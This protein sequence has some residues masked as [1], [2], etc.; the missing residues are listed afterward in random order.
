MAP[1]AVSAKQSQ[2]GYKSFVIS[3]QVPNLAPHHQHHFPTLASHRTDNQTL[4]FQGSLGFR[5]HTLSRAGK[6]RARTPT[7]KQLRI[8]YQIRAHTNHALE[9][10]H[11]TAQTQARSASTTR[12]DRGPQQGSGKV[13]GSLVVQAELVIHSIIIVVKQISKAESNLA[14]AIRC[15]PTAHTR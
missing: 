7:N 4:S 5:V 15:C 1:G 3:Q 11:Y 13:H 2:P 12:H 8:A 10:T 6:G 9:H 14:L